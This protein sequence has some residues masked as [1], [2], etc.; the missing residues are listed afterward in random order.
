MCQRLFK[1]NMPRLNV[2][3]SPR[4]LL[5]LLCF[6]NLPPGFQAR[7]FGFILHSFLSLTAFC[8]FNYLNVC[9]SNYCIL[10]TYHMGAREICLKCKSDCA[11]LLLKKEL[12]LRIPQ[13]QNPIHTLTYRLTK[14]S[15]TARL[16]RP[17][18]HVITHSAATQNICLCSHGVC[19]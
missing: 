13:T 10:S 5:F 1:L 12:I 16:S 3:L 9:K 7:S 18:R 14:W 8:Q 4:N 19:S 11:F 2:P 6:R 15:C 17:S